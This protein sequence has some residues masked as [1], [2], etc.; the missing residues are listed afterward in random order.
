MGDM[1]AA[2]AFSD[3]FPGL[4]SIAITQQSFM[5]SRRFLPENAPIFNAVDEQFEAL[6]KDGEE[7]VVALQRFPDSGNPAEQLAREDL[8]QIVDESMQLTADGNVVYNA[9]QLAAAGPAWPHAAAPPGPQPGGP[10]PWTRA[11]GSRVRG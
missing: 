8:Q 11:G 10:P 7:A 6:A 5:K 9:A 2:K 3:A 4:A 1:D